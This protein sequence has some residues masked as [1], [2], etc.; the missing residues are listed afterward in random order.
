MSILE[1]KLT[2]NQKETLYGHIEN[3]PGL[4]DETWKFVT[5]F[6]MGGLINSGRGLISEYS[7][8]IKDAWNGK[9]LLMS[10]FDKNKD[11]IEQLGGDFFKK[12]LVITLGI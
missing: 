10:V 11:G 7:P 4:I 9:E 5:P 8:F 6:F 3:E 1:D 12:Y 2:D